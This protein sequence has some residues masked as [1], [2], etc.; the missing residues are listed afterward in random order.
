MAGIAY[1][2][3]RARPRLGVAGGLL[4]MA[5]LLGFAAVIALDGFTWAI[6]G[7]VSTRGDAA[8]SQLALHDVQQS[9]WALQYYLLA[10]AWIPGMLVLSVGLVRAGLAPTWAG[11]LLGVAAVL[12]GTEGVIVS[13]AYY[14]AGAAVFLVAGIAVAASLARPGPATP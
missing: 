4:T 13:N 7:E 5:G 11:A 8:T 12:V 1:L 9:E 6:L 14:I 10:F 2:V 3:A